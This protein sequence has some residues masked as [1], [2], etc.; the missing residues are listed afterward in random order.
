MFASPLNVTQNR[1]EFGGGTG[2]AMGRGRIVAGGNTAVAVAAVHNAS[3][4][5]RGMQ[6]LC[7]SMDIRDASRDRGKPVS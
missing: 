7:A 4:S 1:L 5:D 2:A 3:L 6:R